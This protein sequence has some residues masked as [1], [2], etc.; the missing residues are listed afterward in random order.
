V[1]VIDERCDRCG[2][3]VLECLVDAVERSLPVH[4]IRPEACVEC[5]ACLEVC[6]LRAIHD[7]P[8]PGPATSGADSP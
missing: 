4:R 5:G 7:R 1:Y 2:Y 3:C 8:A 6:P